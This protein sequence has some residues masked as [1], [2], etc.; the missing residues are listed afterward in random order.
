MLAMMLSLAMILTFMPSAVFA[1]ED[2]GAGAPAVEGEASDPAA[3]EVS[4]TVDTSVSQKNLS[5]AGEEELLEGFLMQEAEL[6]IKEDGDETPAKNTRGSKLKGNDKVVY[7]ELRSALEG[8]ARG[9]SD[10]T[11]INVPASLFV[12]GQTEFTAEDLG[13][14][15]IV[16]DGR[17][18]EAA[19]EAFYAKFD[20]N[21]S[22][23][24]TSL[25]AD[26]PYDLY[27]F[28]KVKGYHAEMG[29]YTARNPGDGIWRISIDESY[30]AWSFCFYVAQ[31]YSQA[32]KRGTTDINKEKT[33]SAG[34]AAENAAE[35]VK[36]NSGRSDYQKL[37]KY[38][39]E[40]C[41]LVTYEDAGL[42]SETPYG[43]IWQ[44]IYVFDGDK[45]TNV[46]CEGYSKAFK[47]LCDLSEFREAGLMSHIVS[48][49]MEYGPAEER[50]GG[51]H[52]WNIVHMG[53]SK[54]YLV[55]VTNCD[56]DEAATGST[57]DLFM[58]GCAAGTG[59]FDYVC[60]GISYSYNDKTRQV[61]EESELQVSGT[62]YDPSQEVVCDHEMQY[63]GPTPATCTEDGACEYWH[64]SKCGLD[65]ADDEG[66]R[67]LKE[68]EKR[69]PAGHKWGEW[70][71]TV[72]PTQ[73]KEGTEIR[74]CTACE[75]EEIR[76]V[77]MLPRVTLSKTTFT[78]NKK[79]QT[80]TVYVRSGNKD[81][82]KN[83]DYTVTLPKGCT[84]V[85]T[86]TITV[87]FKGNYSG[88]KTASYTIVPKGSKITRAAAAKRAVTLTWA[89]Q[90]NK[91]PKVITG[92][93]IQYSLRKDFKSGNKAVN[94]GGYTKTSR[95]ITGLASKK[96][97]YFRIRTYS[98][99]G[100]K[101]YYS[102]WSAY[103]AV[104][105]K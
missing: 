53:D 60:S 99:I 26:M 88:T 93:Q 35:I 48:G 47:V 25:I 57:D 85:G 16:E 11:V 82:K 17:I 83:T 7:D 52:M 49:N 72:E 18:T 56:D 28:D 77:D 3:A 4:D 86:Y 27:W 44:V 90:V 67:L 71:R 5:M 105:V 92:Y 20:F 73:T 2:A 34:T 32:N 101:P 31:G 46:V 84:N 95:K 22:K 89:K 37:K 50:K 40:I 54:N 13:V 97:Y 75:A 36:N 21:D 59:G 100:S 65:F 61:Y 78:W 9:E 30:N 87:K 51:P 43:D 55:D 29:E 79:A 15:A 42:D 33:A 12:G 8:I 96:I 39:D 23:V 41:N 80:P 69:I 104:K 58:K 24:V 64:C 91:M 81:L 63:F 68:G 10:S 102:S 45:T 62:D 1:V 103:K 74:K 38:K 6:S 98:K 76:A 14:D 66:N 94:V 70:E 19:K